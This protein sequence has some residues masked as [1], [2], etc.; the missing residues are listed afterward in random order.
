MQLFPC[1]ESTCSLS[2]FLCHAKVIELS[3][4]KIGAVSYLN[5]KPLLYGMQNETFLQTH[6]LVLDYPAHIADMLKAGTV[7]V[8]L[9]PV[10]MLPQLPQYFIVSDYGIAADYDVASVCLFSEVP[11]GK[12]E[13]IYLDYQSRSSAAL[14]KILMKEFWGINPQLA[15]ARDETYRTK[16]NGTAAALV[17]G[18]RAFEQ[19]RL[20]TYVYDLAA[21]WRAMTSL[22]FVFAVWA[23]IKPMNAQWINNFNAVNA[24]GLQ[25][26]DEIAEAQK[27][28][29]FDLKKYYSH[30]IAYELTPARKNG[31][32]KFLELL[33]A[34]P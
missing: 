6:E 14:L 19:R 3:K 18:D 12:I 8:G 5:T 1:K 32:I 25:K 17:I 28:S 15:E 26:L 24:A 10:A 11:V 20:S 30:H 31:M 21:E 29:Q 22:P 9:V 34:Y 33:A 7:D 4:I 27:F 23:G 16:I 13:I 2:S